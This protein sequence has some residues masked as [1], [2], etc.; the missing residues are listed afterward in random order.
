MHDYKPDSDA[1]VE[2]PEEK[3]RRVF[4]PAQWRV[5]PI[6]AKLLAEI[7]NQKARSIPFD[8]RPVDEVRVLDTG[9]EERLQ[10]AR[11]KRKRRRKRGW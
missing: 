11:D 3:L 2:S 6:V 1:P 7:A 5:H 10:A 4:N 9:D 8:R